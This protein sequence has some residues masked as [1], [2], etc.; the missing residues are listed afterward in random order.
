MLPN[1]SPIEFYGVLPS[2]NEILQFVAVVTGW[3]LD[4][5]GFYLVI[6]KYNDL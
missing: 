6:T 1:S 2:Y 5:T 4:F 3:L